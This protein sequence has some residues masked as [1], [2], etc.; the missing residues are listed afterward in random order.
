MATAIFFGGR[1]INYPGAYSEIDAEALASL[2]PGAVGIVALVG[3]A[4]GGE[5]LTVDSSEVDATRPESILERF[6][7]GDLRTAGQFAFEPSND[8][9]IP[10]GAQ[11]V[12]AVKVNPATQSSVTLLDGAGADS[13]DLLSEDYGQF[14]EQINIEV[15]AGTVQGKKITLVFED[16]EEILDDVGGDAVINIAYDPGTDGYD[17]VT[18]LF[19]A[20]DFTAAA[21]K[22]ETGLTAEMTAVAPVGLPSAVE[23][24][25]SD[26]ADT[27]QQVTIYG[28]VGTTATQETVS[29]NGTTTVSTTETGWT[30]ILGVTMDAV[31]AG[32]VSVTDDAANAIAS[33]T[34][35]QTARGVVEVTNAPAAGALTVA[36]D[37]DTAVD[38]AI[39]GTTNA[40]GAIGERFDMTAGATTPVVGSTTFG[41][42]SIIALGEVAAARTI[43]MTLDS[44]VADLSVF[45][46][47][48]R[49]TDR[50][51][52][53]DGYT[54]SAEVANAS[55]FATTDMDYGAAPSTLA[56]TGGGGTDFLADLYFFIEAINK[57]SD[58]VDATRASGASQVPAN[59]SSPIFLTGGV[60]GTP[61]I[62]EWQQAFNLLKKRRCNII[63]PLTED[64]A[65]H[66]LLAQHLR[67]RAGVLRSEANG[68]VG[69]GTADGAGETKA[70]IKTQIQTL[71]GRNISAVSQ[72]GQRFDPVTGDPTWYPPYMVAAVAAGMQ[73]GSPIAEPLTFKRPL[74]TDIRQ[75]DSWNPEDDFEEMIDA[76]LMFAEKKDGIGIRWVRSVTTYLAD[77]NVVFTEM[78]ANESANTAVF[79]LRSGLE[80]KVGKRGLVGTVAAIKGLANDIL[81]R[82]IDD[83]IIFAYR[84]L[85]VEQV[86]DVFP[87]SVE[88]AP[89]LPINFIP[90]TV[91]LVAARAAA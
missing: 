90:I 37:V 55:T 40:G 79:E 32:T 13:V 27:T 30:K 61:T 89:I 59:T 45:T 24:V 83:E 15:E 10:G 16:T 34:P 23:V 75:D 7:S 35:G 36:I 28:L 19:D 65:V 11:R 4:E 80:I 53:L 51:N 33:L 1:R 78:S 38:V 52:S 21:T 91:H 44:V 76:G 88:I 20:S 25:S 6:R 54:A 5:P 77:D 46:T 62:T 71:A 74:F 70:N 60:E 63:V 31:A 47:I 14:T 64:A 58:L 48:Q 87:V 12:I 43:T 8:D 49:L 85:S 66:N 2:A 42:V 9:A 68:Y 57:G 86:G 18:G 17:T 81:S 56:T 72:E 26:G 22:A 41:T 67:L 84:S 50:L 39:F 3:T 69:I 82:L 73:A 29:L